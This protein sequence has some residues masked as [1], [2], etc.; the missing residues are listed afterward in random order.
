MWIMWWRAV[1]FNECY[2][3]CK[4]WHQTLNKLFKCCRFNITNISNERLTYCLEWLYV[5]LIKFGSKLL[6]NLHNWESFSYVQYTILK[7]SN[8]STL[9][10]CLSYYGHP[11]G[12]VGLSTLHQWFESYFC[13]L[14]GR[15]HPIAL[16]FGERNGDLLCHLYKTITIT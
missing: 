12:V 9:F 3:N 11:G 8:N 10:Y 2:L 5:F 6:S 14:I 13:W 15:P 4:T 16:W 7:L 1:S